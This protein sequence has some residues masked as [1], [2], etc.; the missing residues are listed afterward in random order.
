MRIQILILGFKG[1]S[2]DEYL[3]SYPQNLE[4]REK[5]KQESRQQASKAQGEKERQ[6]ARVRGKK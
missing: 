2:L 3:W 6:R 1:L 5:G 4:Y